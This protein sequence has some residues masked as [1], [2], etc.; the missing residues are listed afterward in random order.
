MIAIL[1][2]ADVGVGRGNSPSVTD[3]RILFERGAEGGELFCTALQHVVLYVSL[4]RAVDVLE[5]LS[6]IQ[7]KDLNTKGEPTFN[8]SDAST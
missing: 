5:G 3:S 4:E 1:A 2:P 8:T 7:R 6:F